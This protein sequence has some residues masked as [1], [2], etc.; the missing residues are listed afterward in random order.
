MG[1]SARR[2]RRPLCLVL[3]LSLAALAS[4]D[5][6][7]FEADGL[8]HFRHRSPDFTIAIP[9]AWQQQA[10]PRPP[11][12]LEASSPDLLPV[13]R[14]MVLDE[15]F[16]LPLRFAS[17]AAATRLAELGRD[18]ELLDESLV[19]LPDGAEANV[20]EVRWTVDVGLGIPVRTLFV[21]RFHDGRWVLVNLTTLDRGAPV[22][23][24]LRALALSLHVEDAG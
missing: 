24:D 12:V 18:I 14:V 20:G 4:A 5:L 16:W 9:W 2:V 15:P 13:V 1:L 3:L 17:R 6:A 21:H 23:A 22:S 8:Y 11:M 19:E 7:T 10:A